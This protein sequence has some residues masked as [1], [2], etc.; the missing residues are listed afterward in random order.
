MC[1]SVVNHGPLRAQFS[2]SSPCKCSF[3][4][5]LLLKS[6]STV[7]LFSQMDLAKT[8]MYCTKLQIRVNPLLKFTGHLELVLKNICLRKEPNG[9]DL[10]SPYHFEKSYTNQ[11]WRS[12]VHGVGLSRIFPHKHSQTGEVTHAQSITILLLSLRKRFY[13]LITFIMEMYSWMNCKDILKIQ[14]GAMCI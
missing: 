6:G 1:C 11:K 5:H 14:C 13:K 3:I 9:Q 10:I 7:N 12:C 2:C 4:S 8:P